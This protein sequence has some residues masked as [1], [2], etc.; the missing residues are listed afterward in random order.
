MRLDV[1]HRL[2]PPSS[3]AEILARHAWKLG[4]GVVVAVLLT[5][6][7][8]GPVYT[9]PHGFPTSVVATSV[10]CGDI[11][12]DPGSTDTATWT[13]ITSPYG[14]GSPYI[15]PRNDPNLTTTDPNNPNCLTAAKTP[16][17]VHVPAGVKL[18]ID[19]SQG[20]VQV[21]SHG[22]GIFVNGGQLKTI[23]TDRTNTVTF[24]AEPDVASWDGINLSAADAAHLGNASLSF[25]SIQHA[26]TAITITSGATSSPDSASYGLTVRNSGIGPSYFD[27][28][29]AINTPISVSGRVD[30][31]TL[32]PDGQFGTLNNIGSQGIKVTYDPLQANYPAA[33]PDKALD[34]ENMTFGSSVPFGETTCVPLQPCA[35]G[36]IG[37]DAIQGNFVTG[38][39][40]IKLDNN[41]FFRAGSYG[42]ELANANNPTITNNTFTCNG[43]GSPK[44]V[45]SCVGSGL[46][47][48]AIYL[49]TVTNLNVA[50]G[51]L[52]NNKGQQN[53]LDAI[54]L[55]GQVVSD[56]TWQTPWNDPTPPST[57]PA[58]P[59]AHTLG[60]IVANGD[61][62]IVNSKL[63]VNDGDVVKVKG[64][65][66][67]ITNGSLNASSGNLKTLT[68]LRDNTVGIQACPSVFV[69]SCPSPLPANEW[70]GLD[71]VG[72][73]GNIVNA[74]I[75]F[76]TKAIDISGGQ[77]SLIGPDGG[78]YGLVVSN[79]RLGPTFSDSVAINT[80][81]PTSVRASSV[82]STPSHRMPITCSA[83]GQALVTTGSTRVTR[84]PRRLGVDSKF[85]A[86]TFRA[87]PMRRSLGRPLAG[88][89]S[90]SRTTP[91]R[92]LGLT[93][94]T[95]CPPTT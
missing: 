52:N 19:G 30:P 45:I 38:Q 69:Q 41:S 3:P 10:P 40:P 83:P 75:L 51:A 47:Y 50:A 29:D 24:D 77:A 6:R 16:D 88:G 43:S 20:P 63:T 94:C 90:I 65:A 55:N 23:F 76:P 92:G 95:S 22:T 87:A 14:T 7:G 32:R 54:V 72:S 5:A 27:G 33:I 17:E 26:L 28:I 9:H 1:R 18:V 70:I 21:F 49:S 4:L 13:A 80:T 81:P 44:P 35:A 67:L 64:G 57:P 42:L 2:K 89:W 56:L 12:L 25:V 86:T 11:K 15:L 66:I 91:S 84:G 73:T 68:S 37:N 74:S 93:A 59:N 78:S 60:Y 36:S 85:S 71:L 31:L 34:V 62:Q 8:A 53:G 58:P 48:S 39:Q 82:A 61:L 79:S 46:R